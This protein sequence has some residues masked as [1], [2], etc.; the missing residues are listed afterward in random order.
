MK[1][2][3]I[4]LD[5]GLHAQLAVVAQLEGQSLNDAIRL[6]VE[7][8]IGQR[9]TALKGHADD[10]LAAIERDAA[11]RREAITALFGDGPATAPT[12]S[13]QSG[14]QQPTARGRGKEG[15]AAR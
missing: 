14:S 11:T 7:A 1:T 6:A 10:A 13:A 3:A 8:Y 5:D 9:K 15:G 4:R 2:M 12:T